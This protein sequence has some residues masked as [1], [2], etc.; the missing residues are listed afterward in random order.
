VQL[1]VIDIFF[2]LIRNAADKGMEAGNLYLD[3]VNIF[4]KFCRKVWLK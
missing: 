1:V 3:K 2:Y 4:N